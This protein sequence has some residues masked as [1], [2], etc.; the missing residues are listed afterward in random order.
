MISAVRQA[1]ATSASSADLVDVVQPLRRKIQSVERALSLLELLAEA[2]SGIRLNDISKSLSLNV[3]TC[4]HLLCTLVDRGYVAQSRKD[5]VYFLGNKVMELSGSRMRQFDLADLAIGDLRTLNDATGETVHLAVL[6]GDELVTIAMLDSR[7]AVRV[8][9]GQGGKSEA[10]HATATGKA[11]LAWLP[12]GEID[13]IVSRCG[14]NRF[15]DKTITDRNVLI[16]ELRQVRRNGFSLDNEEFQPGVI[17]IGAAIR[18]HAGAV[19]GAISCSLPTMRADEQRLLA[20]QKDVKTAARTISENLGG[21]VDPEV[22]GVS[23]PS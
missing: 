21:T 8:V 6:Q 14:L 2:P 17:C 20:V 9:S 12:E 15:T 10:I 16:E 5:R 1:A 11:M 18:N 23:L 3:S 7:H 4:H 19:V 22:D 13:R